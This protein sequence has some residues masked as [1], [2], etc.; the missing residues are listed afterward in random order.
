[1]WKVLCWPA[2]QQRN[3]HIFAKS[4]LWDNYSFFCLV[5]FFVRRFFSLPFGGYHTYFR[6]FV[7]RLS[8]LHFFANGFVFPLSI[9]HASFVPQFFQFSSKTKMYADENL[10]LKN[11]RRNLPRRKNML[12][13]PKLPWKRKQSMNPKIWLKKS[14]HLWQDE[15]KFEMEFTHISIYSL[16]SGKHFHAIFSKSTVKS[17]WVGRVNC[18]W[19]ERCPNRTISPCNC[20]ISLSAVQTNPLPHPRGRPI[21]SAHAQP[22]SI[23]LLHCNINNLPLPCR[24]AKY[25]RFSRYLAAKRKNQGYRI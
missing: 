20:N 25:S 23:N 8:V 13:L 1:M 12:S 2:S 9:S 7:A 11:G 19:P 14:R 17:K 18:P 24:H 21:N 22:P 3:K 16:Q 6:V 5:L 4:G 10:R 15:R